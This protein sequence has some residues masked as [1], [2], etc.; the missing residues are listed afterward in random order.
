MAKEWIIWTGRQW[1]VSSFGMVTIDDEYDIQANALGMLL[2]D[3]VTPL[4]VAQVAGKG[5]TDLDDFMDAFT[6]ALRIHVGKFKPLPP[7]WR[8]HASA[9]I[10]KAKVSRARHA[11]IKQKLESESDPCGGFFDGYSM[12]AYYAAG[13]ELFGPGFYGA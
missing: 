2:N 10:E 11:L 4:W 9:C 3:G 7:D 6:R 8:R 5:S 13:E 1:A 12:K